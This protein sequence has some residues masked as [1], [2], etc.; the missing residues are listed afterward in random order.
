MKCVTFAGVA[1]PSQK[2]ATGWRVAVYW[3]EGS[4]LYE[5]EIVGY[6]NVTGRHH[7]RY[8]S[9]DH[10]HVSLDAVRWRAHA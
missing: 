6:D 4:T 7:V 1:V 10:E 8:D 5:G 9:G 3:P 2:E